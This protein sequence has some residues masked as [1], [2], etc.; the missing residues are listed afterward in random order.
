[1]MTAP[2]NQNPN[3][4]SS[5]RLDKRRTGA[6]LVRLGGYVLRQWYLF[7][8]AIIM[9]LLSN[10][11]A[12]LGPR[13]SGAAIDAV[14]LEGGVDMASVLYNVKAMIICYAV[15]AVFSYLLTVIMV[16]LSQ[17]IVRKMRSQVFEKLNTLPVGFFDTTPTG[18]IISRISYDI[19]T[20]NGKIRVVSVAP[21]LGEAIRRIHDGKSVSPLF[22]TG[23]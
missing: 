12:L 23:H 4:H 16:T 20:L 3:K 8:P 22:Y 1:M 10:H 9:T 2:V 11:L 19:D 21:L 6:V 5:D 18:D 14:N 13:Y 7:F 17:R 15:S